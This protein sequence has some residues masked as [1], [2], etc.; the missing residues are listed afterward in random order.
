MKRICDKGLCSLLRGQEVNSDLLVDHETGWRLYCSLP[1]CSTHSLS[2]TPTPA[3]GRTKPTSFPTSGLC[4]SQHLDFLRS[5]RGTHC[6]KTRAVKMSF[7]R[8]GLPMGG[9]GQT[10]AQ[11][12]WEE[13]RAAL[14][15]KKLQ[16]LD[17]EWDHVFS[18]GSE[19]PLALR[20]LCNS[21]H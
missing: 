2:T 8:M 5:G 18:W 14:T 16:G 20:V 3:S 19:V 4:P 21:G 9:L 11:G 15:S 13:G 17:T 6:R 1:L 7:W 12:Y 10:S